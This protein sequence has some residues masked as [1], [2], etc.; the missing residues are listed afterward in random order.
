MEIISLHGPYLR[1]TYFCS[2][3]T[4][5]LTHFHCSHVGTEL[6]VYFLFFLSNRIKF[7]VDVRSE[8]IHDSALFEFE[9]GASRYITLGLVAHPG[10]RGFWMLA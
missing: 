6:N 4:S 9:I 7:D 8:L 3:D 1:E 10:N 5:V 2:L